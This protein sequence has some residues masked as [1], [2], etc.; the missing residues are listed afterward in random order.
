MYKTIS[1][2]T[3]PPIWMTGCYL[4]GGAVTGLMIYT[5]SLAVN[6]DTTTL[7]NSNWIRL[8]AGLSSSAFAILALVY[9]PRIMRVRLSSQL[10]GIA[11]KI[12]INDIYIGVIIAILYLL[13]DR[14]ISSLIK[15]SGIS[16]TERSIESMVSV[17][18][19]TEL[20]IGIFVVGLLTAILEE[21]LFR[22][23]LYGSYKKMRGSR[24]LKIG[25]VSLLFAIF[26][27]DQMGLISYFI[28][29][30]MLCL[31]RDKT[32]SI[33]AGVV[34]HFAN[35]SIIM[36]AYFFHIAWIIQ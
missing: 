30:V 8:L 34:G 26:H 3:I 31:A 1:H 10:L 18:S 4:I 12:S 27:F 19:L 21:F 29:S 14:V 35:N 15:I 17:S 24:A 9:L 6:K 28:F 11:R 16:I 25:L 32:G 23:Y 36:L 13:L 7:F 20:I 5:L 33:W 22:G 2:W